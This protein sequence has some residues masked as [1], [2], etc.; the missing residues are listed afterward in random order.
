[1][2][3]KALLNIIKNVAK[4]NNISTPYIVGG[5]ARDIFLHKLKEIKDVDLTCGNK[6][7]V[8]L[9]QLVVKQLPKSSLT[10]FND[11][12][13]KMDFDNFAIDF[14]NNFNIPNIE[15]LLKMIDINNPTD[16]QKELYS[17]DFNVNTL[18]MPLDMSTILDITGKGINEINAKVIDTC[19]PP[20]ITLG[21][22]PKRIIRV[23]YLCCKLSFKPSSRVADWIKNNAAEIAGRIPS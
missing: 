18:L 4:E 1:M 14:S 15:A 10:I 20:K 6:D 2:N 23:V 22:D 9:G 12:H 21:Y 7:S 16:M 5:L 13:A 17:R 11:G 8:K 19:L 3:L